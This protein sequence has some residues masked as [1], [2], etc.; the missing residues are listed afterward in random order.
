MRIYNL[1]QVKI[2]NLKI[3]RT[4]NTAQQWL[5]LV[6]LPNMQVRYMQLKDRYITEDG[7]IENG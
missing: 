2:C 3:Y 1:G 5:A 7:L 6:Y 4:K